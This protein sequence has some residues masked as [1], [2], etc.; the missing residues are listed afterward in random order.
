M[1]NIC[2]LGGSGFVGGRVVHRL[3]AAGYRVTV[4]T[5]R[6]ESAKH[7]SVLPNVRIEV[8]D[9]FF[10]A[11]LHRA[12]SGFDAVINLVGILHERGEATFDRVHMEL[13]RRV[14]AACRDNGVP[15]LLQMSALNAAGNAPSAYLRSRAAGERAARE[16]AGDGLAVTVFCPSV[17]FGRGD[18][19]FTLFAKLARIAP[20][21]L[22]AK[23]NARFQPIF[24]EDVARAI[25]GSLEN[26]ATLG[27]TYNLCG[28]KTYTLRQLLQYVVA[29]LGVKRCIVGLN[30]RLSYLQAW[31][32]ERLPVKLMTRDNID[33]MQ[34]DSVCDCPF[35]AV[36]GIQPVALE[37]EVPGYIADD[38]PR[39]V[40]LRFRSKAGRGR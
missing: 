14:A 4:L 1:K 10:D 5:R 35:P 37:S 16:A 32:M 39:V 25:V 7:L 24:V 19:F 2:V 33:S 22:L 28:P 27:Q 13:P 11:A 20:V 17:I 40:Y 3:S 29:T 30:D 12:L 9:V 23:P 21:L 31:M 15:R 6:R 26:P 18:S 38:V 8:C 34:V 36:F